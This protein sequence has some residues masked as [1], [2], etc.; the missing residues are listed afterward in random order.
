MKSALADAAPPFPLPSPGQNERQAFSTETWHKAPATGLSSVCHRMLSSG[1]TS[2]HMACTWSRMKIIKRDNSLGNHVVLQGGSTWASQCLCCGTGYVVSWLVV[3][4]SWD[5]PGMVLWVE[6]YRPTTSTSISSPHI[7]CP[8]SSAQ[9]SPPSWA[10]QKHG[11][12]HRGGVHHWKNQSTSQL[13]F[14]CHPFPFKDFKATFL[15]N[16]QGQPDHRRKCCF[17]RALQLE[18]FAITKSFRWA[19]QSHKGSKGTP[20]VKCSEMGR[21][22]MLGVSRSVR[23]GTAGL[24]SQAS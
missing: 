14:F 1:E 21:C 16:R 24:Q 13:R 12:T 15:L 5:P 19:R 20:R 6:G 7:L 2:P 18:P 17:S 8:A 3:L 9:T 4:F 11:Y 23:E 22:A 10:G